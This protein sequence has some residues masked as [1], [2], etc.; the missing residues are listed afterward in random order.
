MTDEALKRA[1]GMRGYLSE[2][3]P[4][5]LLSKK[6]LSPATKKEIALNLLKMLNPPSSAIP[7]FTCK[8][9]KKKTNVDLIPTRPYNL[10]PFW[11]QLRKQVEN[12][13]I[14]EDKG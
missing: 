5:L 13:L 12:E 14:E 10:G 8:E 11:G 7:G 6:K 4:S 9:A 2:D 1:N 3:F